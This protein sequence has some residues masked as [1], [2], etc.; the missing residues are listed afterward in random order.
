MGA[1]ARA[2]FDQIRAN[3]LA[4]T[5][6]VMVTLALGILIGT[7]ISNGVKAKTSPN[8]SDASAIQIPAPKQLSN[9]FAQ[10]AKQLEP[11]VVNIN[12]ESIAKEDNSPQP[13]QR[14]RPGQRPNNPNN[15][16][17]DEEQG[18]SPFDDFF[19]RFFGGQV[20]P[21][22]QTPERA[23]GSGVI[24]DGKGYIITNR[25]VIEGAD[26]I[27]VHLTDDPIGQ[28]YDAKVIGQDQETDLA[29]I[30]I[31]PKRALSFAKLGNSDSEVVGNW[32][33]AI[34]SPFGQEGTVTAGIIS[35]KGRNI[36]PGRQF[37]SFIQTD[38]AINPGN[39][40]G[41]LV[42]M[43]GEVI[44]INTAIFTQGFSQGYMGIGFAMPSNTVATVYNQLIGAEH[45]VIRG[46]IGVLFNAQANPA[47]ERIYGQGVTISEVTPK[48]P[49]EGAGLK[50]GDTITAIDGK[51]IKNGDELVADIITR[52]PGTKV[53]IDYMRDGKP[54]SASVTVT[55]REKLFPG[56]ETGE[57]QGGPEAPAESKLGLTVQDLTAAMKERLG[58]DHGVVITAVKP[59]SWADDNNFNVGD[60]IL[61][62]NRQPVNNEADFK[63]VQAGLKSGQD[64]V[65]M[66]HQGGR[67]G[68]GTI[69]L[70][71]TLP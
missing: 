40:G 60:V 35:A 25:H 45:R 39:S 52:K 54:Q 10:I 14:R 63:R 23:L 17:N 32:V 20:G 12:T 41:P 22:Q 26:R 49:S 65:C 48:G 5:I 69:F 46:S 7:V 8:S 9:A 31:E 44:G 53:K 67:R 50:P 51:K 1:R 70:G 38:A 43:D 56:T 11:A 13:R 19:D 36:V 27:K 29:V 42:N 30:K 2:T 61:Q 71:G 37:Q 24:V 33:L 3:R 4:S 47:V 55:D 59:G 34:G 21:Q 58:V 57:E 18:Q 6:L 15:P 68:G 28:N 62:I 66:V 64:V 16:N